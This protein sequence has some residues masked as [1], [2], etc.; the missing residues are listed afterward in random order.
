MPLGGLKVSD[1]GVKGEEVGWGQGVIGSYAIVLGAQ[2]TTYVAKRTPPSL[3][4]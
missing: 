3:V 1:S 4:V 2:M